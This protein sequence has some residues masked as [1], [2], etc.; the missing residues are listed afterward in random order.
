MSP[1]DLGKV[2][3]EP[4]KLLVQGGGDF[5]AHD[6]PDPVAYIDDILSDEGGGWLAGEEKLGKS[7]YMAEEC[8]C[9]AFAFP[10]CGRFAVAQRRRVLVLEE[11]DSPRRLR[12]RFRALLRGHG[13]DPEASDVCTAFNTWVQISAW[14]G[15]SLDNASMMDQ[16]RDAIAAFTPD[17]VY[18][19]CLRKVTVR[20]LNHAEEASVLLAALDELRREFGCI[21]RLIHHYR[22]QQGFRTARGSQE[23]GG[24]YVLGAWGE[25]SLFFEPVG[26]KQGAVR[27]EVQCKDSA[28]AP[29]FRL[30]LETEGPAHAPTLVRLTAEEEAEDTSADDV[31]LQALA[32]APKTEAVVGLPGVSVVTLA[33]TLKKSDKT[34][35]RSLKRLVTAK[36]ALVTGQASRQTMLYGLP[37]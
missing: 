23:I 10:V 15:F 5:L 31:L 3:T 32:A 33:V 22:K 6:D 34:I 7:W 18:I 2:A 8:V 25:N 28:P 9:L 16:L 20:N 35:R 1:I 37:E 13:L 21:F 30:H 12:R 14:S 27:V 26:R 11:E 36:L 4:R 24:S 19:D 17:I 29:A